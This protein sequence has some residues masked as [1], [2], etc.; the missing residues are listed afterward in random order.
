MLSGC[1]VSASKHRFSESL[2]MDG[3][4]TPMLKSADAQLPT[5]E[6][7]KKNS[8]CTPPLCDWASLEKDFEA[9]RPYKS[10]SGKP[11][12]KQLELAC[13]EWIDRFMKEDGKDSGVPGVL[14]ATN[15]PQSWIP[16][17]S[18]NTCFLLTEDGNLYVKKV[19]TPAHSVA[20]GDVVGRI[21]VFCEATN[22]SMYILLQHAARR[23]L[24]GVFREIKMFQR[25]GVQIE[26]DYLLV[27]KYSWDANDN[28][29]ARGV[30]EIEYKHRGPD[31]SRQQ[32]FD[33]LNSSH[34]HRFYMLIRIYPRV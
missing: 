22:T 25:L 20:R 18:N 27:P 14:V 26:P 7:K 17:E 23:R 31:A 21:G 16:Q 29:K 2:D 19:P 3:L 34:F 11:S 8:L 1:Q 13:Q 33:F 15:V 4:L 12:K 6:E 10:C 5:S 30:I 28:G 32:G 9:H 24:A